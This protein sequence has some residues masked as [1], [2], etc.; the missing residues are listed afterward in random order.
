MLVVD[1]NPDCADAVCE[2][3]RMTCDW[4]VEVAYDPQAALSLA[5]AHPPDAVF[6]D[7]EMP[8]MNGFE[9]ADALLDAPSVTLPHLVAMTGNSLLQAEAWHDPRFDAS[10]LKPA[11]H[12]EML[13][14]L[15]DFAALKAP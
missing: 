1:D 2:L 5:L 7:M 6:L 13:R 4:E 11:G 15:A 10:L 3:I 12:A 9:T 8:G 14:L